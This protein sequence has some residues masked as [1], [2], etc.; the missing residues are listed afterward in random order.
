MAHRM[1]ALSPLFVVIFSPSL[2]LSIPLLLSLSSSF[3]L[4]LFCSHIPVLFLHL[5]L[6]IFLMWD[7]K[8]S[9]ARGGGGKR[10]ALWKCCPEHS[11]VD[12]RAMLR[13]YFLHCRLFK[14]QVVHVAFPWQQ[15]PV[16]LI[17][18]GFWWTKSKRNSG[19]NFNGRA[20]EKQEPD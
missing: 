10:K 17:K 8:S 7:G 6:G 13:V 11:Q 19:V 12:I 16:L 18:S 9:T 4:R 1:G 3:L 5:F 20:A 15:R 2:C 14:C